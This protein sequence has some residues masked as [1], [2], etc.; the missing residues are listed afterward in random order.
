MYSS[1]QMKV[2]RSSLVA[3]FLVLR[4]VPLFMYGFSGPDSP[5]L[6]LRTGRF[7][8]AEIFITLAACGGTKV[9]FKSSIG[10]LN[11]VL[12]TNYT[13]PV[14]HRLKDI[15]QFFIFQVNLSVLNLI[16]NQL[17]QNNA[18]PIKSMI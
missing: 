14:F 1:E 16:Y 9:F 18:I 17:V 7:S 2:D 11:N 8:I 12:L 5:I 10:V 4:R 13:Y 3:R 6:A 15:Y